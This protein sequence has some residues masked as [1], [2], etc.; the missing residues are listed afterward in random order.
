MAFAKFINK[1]NE[2][3]RVCLGIEHEAA[4]GRAAEAALVVGVTGNALA[5]EVCAGSGKKIAVIVEAVQG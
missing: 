5:A 3:V 1:T 4:S 2:I